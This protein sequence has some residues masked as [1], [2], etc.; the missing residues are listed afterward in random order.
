M[1]QLLSLRAYAR[2]RECALS[3]VQKAIAS[4]RISTVTDSKGRARIDPEVADIQWAKNTDPL[5]SLRATG[6]F[7]D[8]AA[9]TET[10]SAGAPEP[11]AD[12]RVEYR[13]EQVRLTRVTADLKQLEL[14]TRVGELAEV[15]PI[16]RAITDTHT[17][18]RNAV[19]AL[20]DRLSSTLAA[21]TDALRVYDLLLAECELICATMQ[22]AAGNLSRLVATE[23]SA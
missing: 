14:R 12:N 16:V 18:A 1:R 4:G 20:P 21:E 7:L 22:R 13:D 15:E 17:A 5:Q 10:A 6:G 23:A 3:A 11:E 2:H 8:A 9:A 19:M